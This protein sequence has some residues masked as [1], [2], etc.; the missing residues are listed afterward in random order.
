M[1]TVKCAISSE[2]EGLRSWH[3]VYRRRTK[4]RISYKHRNLQGQGRKVTW[5]V[6]QVLADKS[7][8]QEQKRSKI[9]APWPLYPLRHPSL[10]RGFG[11]KH[12]RTTCGPG[13]SK[14]TAFLGLSS[15]QPRSSD[16]EAYTGVPAQLPTQFTSHCAYKAV[17]H[18]AVKY[19]CV[20]MALLYNPL[21]HNVTLLIHLI[22]RLAIK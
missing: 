16:D 9:A 6:W 14:P 15:P 8:K 5:C 4:T 3:L 17:E 18:W 11:A 19:W 13:P 22:W 21:L 2:R 10:H 20:Q 1:L 7:K 12:L